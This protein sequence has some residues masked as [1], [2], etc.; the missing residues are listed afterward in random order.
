MCH[1]KDFSEFIQTSTC[2]GVIHNIL[3]PVCMSNVYKNFGDSIYLITVVVFKNLKL[4]Q[5]YSNRKR[6]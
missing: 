5:K 2:L 1:R 4:F 6:Y 3:L